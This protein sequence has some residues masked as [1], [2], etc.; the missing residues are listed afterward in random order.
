MQISDGYDEDN[1]TKKLA[2]TMWDGQ[3]RL[4]AE[5]AGEGLSG[6]QALRKGLLDGRKVSGISARDGLLYV[7]DRLV[8]PRAADLREAV[9]RLA[10]DSLG[11][12]GGE[13][14]YLAIRD[15]FYWPHMR[16]ELEQL[17]VP[18]CEDCQR[19]KSPNRKPPGPLHPLPVPDGRC[20]SVAID[21]IGPL[22]EDDGFDCIVTMTDRLNSDFR[23]VPCRA[24][25]SAEDFAELFFIHWYS[26]NG[27]PLDIVSDRD[28]LFI[29]R[30]WR[31]LMKLTGVKQKMS[32]AYHPETDG[33]SE[34]TNRTVIQ[35]LR[36]HV[37]CNQRGWVKA[38]PL[39]CFNYMN[40]VNS[41]T[42]FTP[43]QLRFGR[44]PRVLPP[45][46]TSETATRDES[47]A[48]QALAKLDCD[49]MEAQDNLHLAKV[50]QAHQAN[51][52]RSPEHRY[53]V[54]DRVW[55]STFHRR[56]EYMQRGSHRVAKFMVQYDGPYT[57]TKANPLASSYTLDLPPSMCIFPTFHSSLL[58]PYL[59]NDDTLFPGRS[60]PEPGPIVTADGSEEYF[61]DRILDRRRV[62]RGWQYLV[63]WSGYGPGSDSWLPGREVADLAALDVYLNENGL[64][65]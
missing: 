5:V 6:L 49:I 53:A 63:R 39:V 52:S 7:G 43:F 30:F 59:R 51:T 33:A 35:A 58:R 17:Y 47:A 10:H 24:D 61:V 48:R 37:Q 21:F 27:L 31:A 40:T 60:N 62:G 23:C 46:I 50:N 29:L 20:D 26:E 41:S 19:N 38:L 4:E 25:I 45:V 34:R 18:S 12:F 32:F 16:K 2:E 28:K 13:K 22:P 11:H 57:V 44:S 14:S 8:I 64:L 56:H 65:A 54:G 3:A 36:F 15:A 1:W 42:G 55:L 9:F